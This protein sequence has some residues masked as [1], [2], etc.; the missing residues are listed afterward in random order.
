VRRGIAGDEVG[1]DDRHL[2]RRW[3]LLCARRGARRTPG[4]SGTLLQGPPPGAQRPQGRRRV[5]G[6]KTRGRS[7]ARPAQA[8]TAMT[9]TMKGSK[10]RENSWP[11]AQPTST[12]SGMAKREIW[13]EEPMATPRARSILFFIATC[14]TV[15]AQRSPTR[16]NAGSTRASLWRRRRLLAEG[17]AS[18]APPCTPPRAGARGAA[19]HQEQRIGE[20]R[21]GRGRAGA[22]CG[23][24]ATHHHRRDVLAGVAR[25]G[26]HDHADEAL[27]DVQRVRHLLDGARQALRAGGYHDGDGAQHGAG[28]GHAQPR[29][30]LL[31]L[32][33]V[34][35]SG[36]EAAAARRRAGSGEEARLAK[37]GGGGSPCPPGRDG[38]CWGSSAAGPSRS[39]S[40][41]PA[42]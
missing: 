1:V 2:R 9:T 31:L 13:M 41:G 38:R 40:S 26:Q 19:G 20:A 24:P 23:A 35:C 18:Q 39:Q 17:A 14:G 22:C 37:R 32:P 3:R 27:R 15:M 33:V 30:L 11:V 28:A 5:Q 8:P 12:T 7:R 36:R 4:P 42:P 29:R 10:L 21:A 6:S 34:P 16:A 25:Y